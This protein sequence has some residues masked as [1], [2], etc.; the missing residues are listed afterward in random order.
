MFKI[1]QK[2]FI[3]L[4]LGILVLPNLTIAAEPVNVYFFY[5]DGCPHCAKEEV[6][7]DKLEK[8]N[9]DITI[10][11]YETWHNRDNAKLLGEV[12]ESLDLNIT[13]VPVTIISD[14]AVVGFG[15]EETTGEKIKNLI[16]E[17]TT[18]GCED[19]ISSIINEDENQ[20]TQNCESEEDCTD[21][22]GCVAKG[23]TEQEKTDSVNLPILGEV[24]IANFSLPIFTILIAAADGFNP[25]AMWVLLFLISL[26][27]GMQSRKK[28]W[29]LGLAFITTSALVYFIFVFAWLKFFLILGYVAWIRIAVGLVAIISGAYHLKEYWAN[30]EGT[31]HVTD[32]NKRQLIIRKLKSIVAKQSFW[33]ALVGIMML[34]AAVNL[35]ELV[36]SAG[37][38]QTFTH[39]LAEANISS[40][41]RYFYIF[42]YI[43]IFMLDDILIFVIAMKTLEMKAI[44][45]KY[46]KWSSLIG[47]VLIL[48][49]GI[50][51]IFKP[52]LIMF[53]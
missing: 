23:A 31:C 28:M 5:G 32:A 20:C 46:T 13:G 16:N 33:L 17:Y 22:C 44:S 53:G 2:L 45:S 24:K 41:S 1:L 18:Y 47:G 8:E 36:C 40:A 52:E 37:F 50:L 12:A 21:D 42:L 19:L 10:Y 51:L 7:L 30:K 4:I 39:V 25:C 6:F 27:L 49:I 11:R 9:K 38:P 35:V 34:A 14:Q 26:L 3:T 48:I 29:T 43:L 15:S